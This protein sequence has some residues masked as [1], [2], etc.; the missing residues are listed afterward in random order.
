MFKKTLLALALTGLAGTAAAAT[1]NTGASEKTVLSMEGIANET[2]FSTT[3]G[4]ADVVVRAGIANGYSVGDKVVF[5]FPNDTF[6]ISTAAAIAAS[7]DDATQGT[8][9]VIVFSSPVYSGGNTVTFTIDTVTQPIL[10]ADKITLSGIVLEKANLLAGGKVAVDFKVV[11]SVNASDYEEKSENI[12][13]VASQFKA[14]VKTK[15][16][17][18][19]DV[20]EE[21]KLFVEANST[22]IADELEI[23]VTN[24]TAGVN[25]ASVATL[26]PGAASKVTVKGDFS[27]LDTD[28][29][30]TADYGITVAES[31]G[32]T[33][34]TVT[35]AEDLQSFSFPVVA[36]TSTYTATVTASDTATPTS[37]P[38]QS[39]TADVALSYTPNT[40]NAS[41]NDSV[42]SF[43]GLDAG[44]WVLNGASGEIAF[45]PFG[46]DYARSITVTNT[47]NLEGE[48][49]VDLTAGGKG[50]TKVLDTKAAAGSVTN[51]SAEVNAFAA[52]K[53]IT[54]NAG[55]KIIVNAPKASV[56]VTGVY[57]HKAT[58][59]RI[60]VPTKAGE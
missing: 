60:L 6:D 57:Y 32:S 19:I 10:L 41:G 53:M 56:S 31:A 25:A 26:N 18:V 33:T 51:I 11:S 42:K 47:S 27:F 12:T 5:T 34:P 2:S 15:L 23:T 37:I 54:G 58:A 13:S 43:T 55:V 22:K 24:D 30:G 29:D 49:T 14:E 21:R 16:D 45:L 59:D 35:I 50:Y 9:P 39:Y 20:N 17:A 46:N 8:A 28:A 4:L 44:E 36:A 48:I 38:V 3:E 7:D 40:A 1:I 52:E